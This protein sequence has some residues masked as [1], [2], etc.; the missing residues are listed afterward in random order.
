MRG[1]FGIGIYHTKTETN[2]GTLIRSAHSFGANFVFTIGRR[3]EKQGSSL[4]QEKHIPVFHFRSEVEWR[5]VMPSN[6]RLVSIEI[7][8]EAVPIENFKHPEMAV[9]LLG[10]EDHGLPDRILRGSYIVQL[11]GRRCL[12]VSTAGSIVMFDRLMKSR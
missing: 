4:N 3:Y 11:P 6:C 10:A 9:Y 1:Y 2:V 5:A 7:N 8:E 12:N